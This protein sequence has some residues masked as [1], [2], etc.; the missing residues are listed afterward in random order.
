M[1]TPEQ[2]KE[3][4]EN[5]NTCPCC[6]SNDIEGDHI[7]PSDKS[8]SQIIRCL[9]CGK[10]WLDVYILTSVEEVED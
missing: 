9:S 7:E 1:L 3:Y 8:A 6:K 4:L 5:P 10:K 2:I